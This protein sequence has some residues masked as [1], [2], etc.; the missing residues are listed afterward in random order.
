[1]L[2]PSVHMSLINTIIDNTTIAKPFSTQ[3]LDYCICDQH[4]LVG[5]FYKITYQHD[6]FKY[7]DHQKRFIEKPSSSKSQNR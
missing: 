4:A 7:V 6:F 5:W 2:P 3:L 1:M